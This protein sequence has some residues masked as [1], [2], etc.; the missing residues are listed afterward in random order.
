VA[1]LRAAVADLGFPLVFKL[2]HSSGGRGTALVTEDTDLDAVFALTRLNYV[3]SDAFLVEEFVD[4]TEHS[5]SGVVRGGEVAIL[6]VTDKLVR[7]AGFS[8]WGTITPS[9]GP[10]EVLRRA[11]ATAVRAIGLRDGGF[12]VD[13]RLTPVGPVVLEVGARLGGDTINS[14]LIPLASDGKVLPYQAILTVL[15]T[16]EMSEPADL[17]RAAA[18]FVFA[19]TDRQVDDLVRHALEHPLVEAAVDWSAPEEKAVAVVITAA[20]A[21]EVY[22]SIDGLRQWMR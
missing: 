7:A 6:G 16:G 11:A 13:L 12:H 15:T 9:A 22:A 14:H 21:D 8:T 10:E 18:M 5:V 3:S 20:S 17:T 4:G 1:E 2:A 19:A